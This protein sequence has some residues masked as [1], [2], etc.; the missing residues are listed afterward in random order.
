MKLH[1]LLNEASMNFDDFDTIKVDP[2]RD[3]VY[4]L[5]EK[6]IPTIARLAYTNLMADKERHEKKYGPASDDEDAY[7]F[8]FD[9]SA[10]VEEMEK[11][12]DQLNTRLGSVISDGIKGASD[13]FKVK[14]S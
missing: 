9:K 11:V 12:I 6:I 3:D 5:A 2:D 7:N 13:S 8:Q 10:L 1:S 14:L 4:D